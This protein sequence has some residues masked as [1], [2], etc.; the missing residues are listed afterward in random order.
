M[1]LLL[2]AASQTTIKAQE[3]V[4]EGYV[5]AEDHQGYLKKARVLILDQTTDEVIHETRSDA[6]GLF[7]ATV[8][9]DKAYVAIVTKKRFFPTELEFT[10]TEKKEGEKVFVKV[11]LERKP[12]YVFDVTLAENKQ[13]GEA[14]VDAIAGA[15]IEIFNN[16]TLREELALNSYPHP[17][18][19]FQF[20][21]GN[22]YTIM[23]RKKGFF[24]KRIE[25]YVDIEDCILCF[26]GLNIVD[27][28]DVMTQGNDIGTF[29]AN[30]EM[31]PLEL[32]K[33]FVLEDIY[34]DYDQSYIRPDAALELDKLVGVLKDN[35]AITVEMGSHTDSRGSDKYNMALSERRAKAAVDYLVETAGV[36]PAKLTWKG[37]GETRLTN[38]CANGVACSKAEHQQNRRT[39][40]KV[41][42]ILETDPLDEKS[43]KNIILEEQALQ[44]VNNSPVI[45]IPVANSESE[46]K[47]K[48]EPK[49]ES[50]SKTQSDQE[51]N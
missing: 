17:S 40:L 35:P 34:Y 47:P 42:G 16:T 15:R 45:K 24:N 21:K 4:V 5:Y 51:K 46:S 37:Y 2:V 27:V 29:L 36:D 14:E 39:E 13:S 30:I 28:T 8:A 48:S 9:A 43:L 31:E 23:I 20:E 12:G 10:T 19:K 32:D 33:R 11:P 18:F 25:A 6:N 26:D 7:T 50:E 3:V 1:G 49:T 22:H 44:E 41:V 38:R